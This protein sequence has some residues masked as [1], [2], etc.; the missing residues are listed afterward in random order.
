[1]MLTSPNTISILRPQ[2]DERRTNYQRDDIHNN[3]GSNIFEEGVAP[4]MS[5][6]SLNKNELLLF[7]LLSSE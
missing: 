2:L 4:K 1:M 7:K 3:T 5:E 6:S